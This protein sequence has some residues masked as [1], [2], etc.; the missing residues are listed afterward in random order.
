MNEPI[1]IFTNS[2]ITKFIDDWEKFKES[3][4][5]WLE[6]RSYKNTSD[7]QLKQLQEKLEFCITGGR[8][9]QDPTERTQLQW[10]AREIGDYIFGLYG[11]YMSTTILP[12][13][14]Q[15]QNF[16]VPYP[17]NPYFTGREGELDAIYSFFVSSKNS[18]SVRSLALVGMGGSGKTQLAIEYAYR[19]SEQYSAIYWLQA[20]D[21]GLFLLSVSE[22]AEELLPDECKDNDPEVM[23]GNLKRHLEEQQSG[24]LLIVDNADDFS[25]VKKYL[26][27]SSKGDILITTR[28]SQIDPAIHQIPI[29]TF[30]P[31][32][33]KLLLLRRAKQLKEIT[34]FTQLDPSEN[35]AAEELTLQLGGLPLAIDQA[36]AYIGK[37]NITVEKYLTRY[38]DTERGKKLRQTRGKLSGEH[39]SSSTT[40]TLALEQVAFRDEEAAELIRI[41]AFL[42]PESIPKRIFTENPDIWEGSLATRLHKPSEFDEL[43]QEATRYSLIQWESKRELLSIHV[44]VQQVIRDEISQEEKQSYIQKVILAVNAIFPKEIEIRFASREVLRSCDR[45]SSQARTVLAWTKDRSITSLAI[46]DLMNKYSYYL[47]ARSRY[48]DAKDF[49]E[50]AV[51]FWRDL[52]TSQDLSAENITEIDLGLASSLNNHAELL[53]AQGNYRDARPLFEEAL[54]IRKDKLSLDDPDYFWVGQSSH[55]LARLEGDFGNY[56]TAEE[57]FDKALKINKNTQRDDLRFLLAISHNDLAKLYRLKANFSE[58]NLNCKKALTIN[59]EIFGKDHPYIASN[60]DNLGD[61]YKDQSRYQEAETKYLQ[62]LELRRNYFRGE[63]YPAIADSYTSLARLYQASRNFEK[64][65]SYYDKALEIQT[66]LF[67]DDHTDIASSYNNLAILCQEQKQNEES[68][69]LY[70]KALDIYK[71]FLNCN[72]P[73][74]AT[75]YNNLA[76]VYDEQKLYLQAEEFYKKALKLYEDTLSKDHPLVAFCSA[77][78]GLFYQ[79]Q[80]RYEEAE[81][82]FQQALALRERRLGE[83]DLDIAH[84]LDNL[85]SLYQDWERY[86]EAESLFKQSLELSKQLLGE[87]DLDI[88]DS[89]DNLASLYQDWE[90]YEK[91]EPLFQQALALRKRLLEEDDLDIADSLD[92]LASLYQEWGQYEEAE[93]LFKQ[94]LELSKRRLG[95]D[96]PDIAY[97]LDNLASLYQDW[98]RY[99]EAEPLFKQSLALREQLLGEDDPDIAYSLDNLALLYQDWERY[100][101]AEPLFK[102]SLALRKRLLEEDDPD[103]AYSL[104]NLA[105]LYQDW[106]RYE[107][108]EPLFKQSLALREQLLGEDDPDIAYSLDN[109]ASLYQDWE[110]YED[111]E[112]LFKQS[113]ALREQLLGEDDLDIAYSLDNLASLYQNLERYEEATESLTRLLSILERSF[114]SEEPYIISLKDRLNKVRK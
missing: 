36:G 43:C 28:S 17:R 38:R 95:E 41:C 92:N 12:L 9:I 13:A 64:A 42:A 66:K 83:D 11:I 15:D 39:T 20:D 57:L 53:H 67:D 110:R 100:E 27:R 37:E 85:A 114:G 91:A 6:I 87:D 35:K 62:A 45:L 59:R 24:W 77:N 94:S 46:G 26:P 44:V 23:A 32:E 47:I 98:E 104:D 52:S 78:L 90:R 8:S 107:E 80:G 31:D 54:K 111:S 74:F 70:K 73:A 82:L 40:Y 22:L 99:E 113:L 72:H 34:D 109:L 112:P 61:I 108:A 16:Y 93:P 55:N 76:L 79:K 3:L 75:V 58:A 97:S 96:D 105:L 25:I 49:C 4:P 7:S 18:S 10:I 63:Y 69:K 29:S 106:E 5:S 68:E 81:P 60:L 71:K 48:K 30:L 89:L 19:Y 88:A 84:S 2:E 51:K 86:E 21:I 1:E 33:S 65:K 102:Q 101:E 56:L 50:C 103:I 14:E